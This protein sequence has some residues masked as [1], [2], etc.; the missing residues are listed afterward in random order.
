MEMV[1]TNQRI[2]NLPARK[3]RISTLD[4]RDLFF[5]EILSYLP[6]R[7]KYMLSLAQRLE[8]RSIGVSMS[9]RKVQQNQTIQSTFQTLFRRTPPFQSPHSLSPQFN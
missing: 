5:K 1:S 3:T 9:K 7:N 2:R 6:A 8:Q 4:R